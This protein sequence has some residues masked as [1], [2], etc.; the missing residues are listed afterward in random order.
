MQPYTT[1]G[2]ARREEVLETVD[3]SSELDSG[4]LTNQEE[5]VL[6]I[7]TLGNNTEYRQINY[8][9]V[10][11]W[12]TVDRPTQDTTT[13][14]SRTAGKLRGH[15]HQIKHE[16]RIPGKLCGDGLR[17]KQKISTPRN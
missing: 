10:G 1:D 5:R 4:E 15:S 14:S 17:I 11:S 7:V 3:S 9:L 6:K 16:S 2:M 8:E 13:P 12:F